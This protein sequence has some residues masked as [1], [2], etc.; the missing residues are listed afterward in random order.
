MSA[1]NGETDFDPPCIYLT[2]IFF[3]IYRSSWGSQ[4]EEA[5]EWKEQLLMFIVDY[6]NQILL[7]SNCNIVY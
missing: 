6:H 1:R 7:L 4:G 3:Q 2:M 5:I